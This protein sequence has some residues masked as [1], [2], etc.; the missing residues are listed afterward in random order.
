MNKC[1]LRRN[2]KVEWYFNLKKASTQIT[3]Y[4][5]ILTVFIPVLS[6]SIMF[7]LAL[8]IGPNFLLIFTIVQRQKRSKNKTNQL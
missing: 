1:K 3:F 8:S 7:A 4:Y 5:W 2:I 6:G